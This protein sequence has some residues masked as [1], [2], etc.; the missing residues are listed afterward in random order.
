MFESQWFRQQHLRFGVGHQNSNPHL[1]GLVAR[2]DAGRSVP[3]VSLLVMPGRIQWGEGQLGAGCGC[4]EGKD[5]VGKRT[6][7]PCMEGGPGCQSPG[8]EGEWG[9]THNHTKLPPPCGLSLLTLT[10][11]LG[12]QAPLF[13]GE[14]EAQSGDSGPGQEWAGGQ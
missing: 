7:W 13:P 10:L 1:P 4:R 2:P 14:T 12:R 9:V 11:P 8:G 5:R 3:L 6:W